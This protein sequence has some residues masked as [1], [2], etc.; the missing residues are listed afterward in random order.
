MDT[1]MTAA[2]ATATVAIEL[3]NLSRMMVSFALQ[4][5]T[6]MGFQSFP[7]TNAVRW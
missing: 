1:E 6:A 7:E 2:A 3:R 5:L 4:C